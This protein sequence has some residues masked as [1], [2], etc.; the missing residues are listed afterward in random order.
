MEAARILLSTIWLQDPGSLS[1]GNSRLLIILV[2]LVAVALT[3]QAIVI[4]VAPLGPMKVRKRLMEIVE[5]VRLKALPVIDTTNGVVHDL[6][7]KIRTITDNFVETSH[8][9]RSKAQEFDSTI[10]DVNHK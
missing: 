4:I 3:A 5:E 6:Q 10:S 1:P 8:V 7:P 2:G 9:V